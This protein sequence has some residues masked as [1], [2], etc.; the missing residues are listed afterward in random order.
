V[1]Q[2]DYVSRASLGSQSKKR[3]PKKK[4]N[5]NKLETVLILAVILL[6]I[7]LGSLYFITRNKSDKLPLLPYPNTAKGLPPPPEERWRYIKELE[8]RQFGVNKPIEPTAEGGVHLSTQ[9]MNEQRK[10]REKAALD[11]NQESIQLPEI[12]S[13]KSKTAKEKISHWVLQCGSF[14]TLEPAESLRAKSALSG[15]ES[16]ITSGDGWNRVILG[17]YSTRATVD[18]MLQRLKTTEASNCIPRHLGG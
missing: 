2:K 5:G 11:K 8:S 7:L 15:I 10:I 9:I 12:P 3:H 1:A 16:S 17:P 13:T 18:D 6:I 14:R 4:K